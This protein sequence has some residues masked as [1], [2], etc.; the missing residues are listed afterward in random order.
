MR[1][2]RLATLAE[3]RRVLALARA[4]QRK[5]ERPQ[6]RDGVGLLLVLLAVGFALAVLAWELGH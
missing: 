1:R 2:S 6:R 5:L 3:Q 4:T